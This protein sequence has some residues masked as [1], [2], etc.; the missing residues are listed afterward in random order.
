MSR[1][2]RPTRAAAILM[3]LLA[4]AFVLPLANPPRYLVTVLTQIFVYA[5]FALSLDLLLG[6]TGLASLGHAAFWG[7]G[8]YAAGLVARAGAPS[9]LVALPAGAAVAGLGA[10]VIGAVC[11]RTGGV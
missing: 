9:V 5:V 4:V 3:V 10:L 2:G 6:Y 1:I 7:L 8:A 11:V